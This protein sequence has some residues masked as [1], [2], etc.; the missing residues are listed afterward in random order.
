VTRI[1]NAEQ[2]LLMLRAHLEHAQRGKRK[3]A[4]SVPRR[5]EAKRDRLDRVRQISAADGLSEAEI[6]EAIIAGLLTEEF[7]PAIANDPNFVRMSKEV[8]RML[9]QDEATAALLSNAIA[10]LRAGRS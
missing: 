8:G 10:Q 7:G 3:G 9:R 2:V 1:T 5:H 6:G 4:A